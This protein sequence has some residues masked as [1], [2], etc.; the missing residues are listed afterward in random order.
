[1]TIHR[2]YGEVEFHCDVPHCHEVFETET[3]DWSQALFE[4]QKSKWN[5][6]YIN[7]EPFHTCPDCLENERP[8]L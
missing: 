6:R 2:N 1:M 3:R 8:K 4:F 7:N 5:L